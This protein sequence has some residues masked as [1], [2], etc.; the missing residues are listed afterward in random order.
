MKTITQGECEPRRRLE[1]A[2]IPGQ[3]GASAGSGICREHLVG[4]AGSTRWDLESAG[5]THWELEEAGRTFP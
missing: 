4:S 1:E 2:R 3:L 5:S